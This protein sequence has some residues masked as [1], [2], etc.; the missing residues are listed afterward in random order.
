MQ[1][2][3][4]TFS[5]V[6]ILGCH[7]NGDGDNLDL[8]RGM[9]SRNGVKREVLGAKPPGCKVRLCYVLAV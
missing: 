9:S 7:S 8:I 5:T 2:T 1:S 4:S 3:D 6:S